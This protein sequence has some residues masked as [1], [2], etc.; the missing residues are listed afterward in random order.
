MDSAAMRA[1]WVWSSEW[2]CEGLMEC[3]N[4]DPSVWLL[5]EKVWSAAVLEVCLS[6]EKDLVAMRAPWVR[7]HGRGHH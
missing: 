2:E 4:K 1:P 3:G 7:L 5:N 6:N